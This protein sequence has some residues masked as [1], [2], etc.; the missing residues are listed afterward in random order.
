MLSDAVTY[1]RHGA[2]F[3]SCHRP[4]N[5]LWIGTLTTK[6][7]EYVVSYTEFG[8][9]SQ[10]LYLLSL[11]RTM[12][13]ILNVYI[14]MSSINVT[15]TYLTSLVGQ[16]VKHLS[17]LWETQ[18]WSLGWEN[19]LEKEM[20]I[21][22]STIAWKIPWTEEPGR[23]QSLGLQRVGHDWATLLYFDIFTFLLGSLCIMKS[24]TIC[25]PNFVTEK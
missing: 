6:I 21:H 20:A 13:H 17:T 24:N 11:R 18:V 4:V 2:S 3:L 15:L 9:W 12:A 16:T 23:L 7:L 1:L 10:H 8:F 25:T 5:C 22:S 19:P 14:R